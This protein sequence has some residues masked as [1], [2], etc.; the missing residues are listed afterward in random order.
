ML[1]SK[2]GASSMHR[3]MHCPGSVK[4]CENIPNTSSAYADE[5]TLAHSWA[6][7]VL[8]REAKYEDIE[9]VGMRKA[10]EMYVGEVMSHVHSRSE[11][12]VEQKFDLSNVHPGLFGTS[13][14]VVYD[15]FCETLR[16]FDFKYG[17]GVPVEVKDNPQLKY[18]ALGAF[19]SFNYSIKCIEMIVVQPRCHHEDGPVRRETLSLIDILKFGDELKV[20][21]E[22]TELADAILVAG[23]HC[24]F[25]P[26]KARCPVLQK[27]ANEVAARSFDTPPYVGRLAGLGGWLS[28]LPQLEAFIKGV[29]EEAYREAI[30]GRAPQGW[31]LVEKR[32]IRRWK[33]EASALET[34]TA[35][36]FHAD[37]LYEKTFKTPP[38]VEKFVGKKSIAP[39]VESISSGLT[40]APES[41]RRPAVQRATPQDFPE[42][43][44]DE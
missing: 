44:D 17:A 14:A 38:K 36:G 6:E 5:G 16:V 33:D 43:L 8:R 29:R 23:N 21:A 3:W 41:D 27:T 12:F 19:N 22:R 31:K 11:L 34:F 32:A 2:I 37:E 9:D 1:H 18:Y 35:L 13:D 10:V 39:L 7:K 25:C 28:K 20:Y 30:N 15:G 42:L 40:L 24:K 4:L 26:A